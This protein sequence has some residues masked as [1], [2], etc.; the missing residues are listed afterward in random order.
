MNALGG[1]ETL[2]DIYGLVERFGIIRE[3]AGSLF[4]FKGRYRVVLINYTDQQRSDKIIDYSK[5]I[6]A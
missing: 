1:S 2:D 4:V 5:G 6:E 3:A